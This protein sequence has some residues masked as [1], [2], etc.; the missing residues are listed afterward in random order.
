MQDAAILLDSEPELLRRAL[1]SGAQDLTVN[2]AKVQGWKTAESIS[3]AM[4]SEV[5]NV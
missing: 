5:C 4:D 1:A 2:L 3:Q